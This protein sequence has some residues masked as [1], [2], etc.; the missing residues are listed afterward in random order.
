MRRIITRRMIMRRMIMRRALIAGGA[1]LLFCIAAPALYPAA[2][3]FT[4]SGGTSGSLSVPDT[5]LVN[6]GLDGELSPFSYYHIGFETDPVFRATMRA[7]AT[8]N[9]WLFRFGVGAFFS[10]VE[11]QTEYE[12][13]NIVQYAPCLTG[14]IG[15][16]E[17]GLISVFVEYGM[18][19]LPDLIDNLIANM[20]YGKLE[21][22]VWIPHVLV[23]GI[24]Q[25][26]SF[27][28]DLAGL[29]QRRY[30]LLRY[31]GMLEF[32]FKTSP[33][34]VSVGGGYE[35]WERVTDTTDEYAES[36]FIA[37]SVSYQIS[38]D[39]TFLL[40]LEVPFTSH[41]TAPFF[42]AAAGIK[43]SLSNFFGDS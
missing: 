17:P 30:S 24:I 12:E 1:V 40:D 18:N 43:L 7:N 25:R 20:N 14:S 42:K 34:Q 36:F 9:L 38:P 5:V 13:E 27:T 11:E 31:H 22:A 28:M 29:Y 39:F 10:T 4:V 3:S 23:R 32:F 35:T 8:F 41:E 21:A 33:L 2:D 6:I 16:E 19:V 15:I 26:K 37:A